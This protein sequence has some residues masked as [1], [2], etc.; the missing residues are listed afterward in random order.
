MRTY[1][2]WQR[3]RREDAY[4]YARRVLVNL[5]TDWWRGRLQRLRYQST[6]R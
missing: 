1:T 3:I 2:A 4:A 6:A 5:H